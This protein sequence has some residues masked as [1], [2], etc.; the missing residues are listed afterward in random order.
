LET[1]DIRDE[2]LGEARPPLVIK[3]RQWIAI[4][5][6]L[7]FG[8][9]LY[10]LLYGS[11]SALRLLELSKEEKMLSDRIDVVKEENANLRRDLYEVKLIFGEE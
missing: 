1:S 10:S 6:L 4:A 8:F 11:N 7:V 3:K 5:A 2:L 9:Y